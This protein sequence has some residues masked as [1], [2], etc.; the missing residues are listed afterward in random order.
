MS[1]NPWVNP[2]PRGHS[3]LK[4]SKVRRAL[5]DLPIKAELTQYRFND[6][7]C[8]CA[9]HLIQVLQLEAHSGDLGR[10]YRHLSLHVLH[11]MVQAAGSLRSQLH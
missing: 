2:K 6:A 1:S 5:A 7:M 8:R 4:A 11:S 10:K 9:E 3:S